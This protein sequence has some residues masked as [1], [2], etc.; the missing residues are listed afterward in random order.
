MLL[1]TVNCK[2]NLVKVTVY[3][4]ST[5]ASFLPFCMLMTQYT[6]QLHALDLMQPKGRHVPRPHT[7]FTPNGYIMDMSER[8]NSKI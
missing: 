3:T 5:A 1:F 4:D 2:L 7:N 8:N 6:T